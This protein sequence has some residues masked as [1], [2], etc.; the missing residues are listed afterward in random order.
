MKGRQRL[1]YLK[2]GFGWKFAC[3]GNCLELCLIMKGSLE[4]R[5]S[6]VATMLGAEISEKIWRRLAVENMQFSLCEKVQSEQI[7]SRR[8]FAGF[9][10]VSAAGMPVQGRRI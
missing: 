10:V 5:G 3:N 6:A 1:D 8:S 9:S 2:S 4:V 7:L